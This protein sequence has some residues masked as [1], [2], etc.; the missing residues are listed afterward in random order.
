MVTTALCAGC[1]T[2]SKADAR[3]RE[4]FIAGQQQAIERMRQAQGPSVTLMGQVRFP[5]IPWTEDLT[6]AKALVQAGYLP[7]APPSDILI[8]RHGQAFHA[9]PAKLLKGEDIPLEQGDVVQ[10]ATQ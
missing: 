2:K 3:A 8:V 5:I 7:A 9:D 6:L 4:A 10:L 1:V